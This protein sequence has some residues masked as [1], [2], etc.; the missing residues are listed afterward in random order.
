MI[1]NWGNENCLIALAPNAWSK[2]NGTV[3]QNIG[4]E[5]SYPAGIYQPCAYTNMGVGFGFVNNGNN[6]YRNYDGANDILNV[7]NKFL[8]DN[9]NTRTIQNKINLVSDGTSSQ[10]FTQRVDANTYVIC[11][12]VGAT[13]KIIFS[14]R[15]GG[16]VAI[17]IIST[18]AVADGDHSVDIVKDGATI[19]II[20]DGVEVAYDQQD[21]WN[22]GAMTPNQNF[23]FGNNDVGTAGWTA[24]MYWNAIYSTA[25]TV[26]RLNTDHGLGNDMGLVGMNTVNTLDLYGIPTITNISP[27]SGD[28]VGA[29]TV[30]ITGT[31][32]GAAQGAGGV[33][34]GGNAATIVS[35]SDTQIVCTAPVGLAG[36]VD[37]VVTNNGGLSVTDVNGYE[38]TVIVI[39]TEEQYAQSQVDAGLTPL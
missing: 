27:S 22:I 10:I 17:S 32:F 8:W 13:R 15:N 23:I 29:T 28:V 12:V 18:N 26:A 2:G 19:K 1:G 11:Y 31:D 38:Y 14:A 3:N 6:G 16:G 4:N 34:F 20:L 9:T 5:P 7:N 35:W 36:F 33:T 21:A 24:I 30:T 39:D 25:L 37:V